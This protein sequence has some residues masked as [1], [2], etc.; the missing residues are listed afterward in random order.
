M[1][2]GFPFVSDMPIYPA[3]VPA[4]YIASNIEDMSHYLIAQLNS[5]RY[6]GTTILSADGVATLHAP[7]AAVQQLG[8]DTSYGMGWFVGP[9]GGVPA[10]YHGGDAHNYHSDMI[11]EPQNGWGAILLVNADSFLA[12]SVAFDHLQTGLARLLAGQE[13]PAPGPR[14]GT[15]YLLIDAVLIVLSVL[16]LLSAARLPRW[17]AR[18]RQKHPRH[19]IVRMTG[20]LLWEVLLPL[21]LIMAIPQVLGYSWWRLGLANPD[22]CSWVLA[23]LVLVLLTGLTRLVLAVML[24]ARKPADPSVTTSTPSTPLPATTLR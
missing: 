24:R 23:L 10:L 6:A 19:Q 1:F 22:I 13:P 16:A 18:R 11:L 14:V 20:R 12:D 8:P 9:L 17:Y 5:G 2:F 7:T 4:G 3:F 15:F 21:L